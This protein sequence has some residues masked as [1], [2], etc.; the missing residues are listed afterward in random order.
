MVV[1]FGNN[2]GKERMLQPA[3]QPRSVGR[4]VGRF[5]Y[6]AE[7]ITR[8]SLAMLVVCF[9]CSPPPFRLSTLWR[10]GP[11]FLVTFLLPFKERRSGLEIRLRSRQERAPSVSYCS[12]FCQSGLCGE[13]SNTTFSSWLPPWLEA[14]LD[15]FL[16]CIAGD[17]LLE[18]WQA[19]LDALLCCNAG[20][21]LLEF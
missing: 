21:S 18:H 1:G 17:S 5:E 9:S 11:C 13:K 8:Q 7:F 3:K 20:Y 14:L 15:A 2:V 4:S 16:C 6:F 19:L 12:K 10:S